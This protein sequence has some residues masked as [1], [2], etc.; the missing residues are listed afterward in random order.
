MPRYFDRDEEFTDAPGAY[1]P[2]LMRARRVIRYLLA[3]RALSPG[4]SSAPGP[5][6][7][8]AERRDC[9]DAGYPAG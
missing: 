4:E 1:D 5:G 2:Q 7:V 9:G 6:L 8:D 3:T